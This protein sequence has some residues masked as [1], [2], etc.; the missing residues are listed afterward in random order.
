MK[1]LEER[2]EEA[3]VLEAVADVDHFDEHQNFICEGLS[4]RD[5][6]NAGC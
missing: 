4:N 6:A 3:V 2:G 5:G 1:V